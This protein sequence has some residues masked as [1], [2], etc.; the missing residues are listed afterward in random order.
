M[1]MELK[2][3]V[4]PRRRQ[5]KASSDIVKLSIN[6]SIEWFTFARYCRRQVFRAST[7]FLWD[8]M[9][10]NSIVA[11]CELIHSFTYTF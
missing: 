6:Q 1:E 3:P 4:F 9:P 2:M 8:S 11:W 10:K 5:V 7:G